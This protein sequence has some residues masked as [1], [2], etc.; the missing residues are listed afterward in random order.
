MGLSKGWDVP[1]PAGF[2]RVL[3]AHIHLAGAGWAGMMILAVMSRLFP[4][5]HLRHPI[6][7]Q[8][9]FAAFNIGL[10]GLTGGLLLGSDWYGIFGSLLAIAC[11]WYAIAFIPIVLEFAQR[12][13]RSTAFLVTSWTCL[14]AVAVIGLWF[15]IVAT[16][17][18]PFAIQLQFVYGF[19]YMFG[20]LSF[21]ILGMLYRIIPTHVS[22]FLSAR[23]I[24]NSGGMRRT[25]IDPALQVMVLVCLLLG[26]IVCSFAILAENVAMF[27][28]GWAIWLIGI[29]GF[30]TGLFRL[31]KELRGL[32]RSTN[33]A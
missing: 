25:F 20:W 12:S 22:K 26:L 10:V 1:L 8:I 7:A 29:F 18:T 4:Q 28:F 6:Q 16:A 9:R 14:A 3:F 33:A 17:T 32:L 30:A 21:M 15:R 2:H 13:D 11:V 31:G 19:V 27:R 24:A 5:P 23:G